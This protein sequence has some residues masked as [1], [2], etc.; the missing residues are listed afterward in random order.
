MTLPRAIP[1]RLIVA[2]GG[3]AIH[4]SGI[5][6]TSE[7]QV[8]IA[9]ETARVLLPI[10]EGVNELIITHGNGPGVGKVL[11]RQAL[12]RDK[13]APMSLDICVANTQGVTAYLLVQ[14]FENALREVGNQRHVVGLVTQ[15]EVDPDD[16]SFSTPTKPVG[17]FYSE[18][19]A[20]QLAETL[21]WTMREDAGRGWRM[22]VGSPRPKHICDISLVEVL[23]SRGTVVIAGGGGGV[24]VVRDARGVRKG[25][26]AVIDKDLTTAHMANVLGI[27]EMIILTAVSRVAI[28]FGRADQ[29]ELD[30]VS[31]S[32][33]RRYLEEG[34][35][36]AGSMG[37]KIEAVIKFIDGGGRRAIIG[38][39]NEALPAIKGETGTHILP[40]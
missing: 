26:E 21:G 17:Y 16:P 22:V 8:A 37:P 10:L 25:V 30:T 2:I 39:L 40:D 11:M 38:H 23:A 3:N 24:P 33:M 28:N 5:R 12:S 31:V 15:V 1:D 29:Q 27:E 14:A 13:V 20:N 35:F 18:K 7:E 19:E 4:P 36:P 32:Q 6:G 34:H 9:G